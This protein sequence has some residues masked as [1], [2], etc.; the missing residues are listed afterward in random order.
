MLHEAALQGVGVALL[1]MFMCENNLKEG[2]LVAPLPN[3]RPRPGIYYAVV[4]SRRGMRPA[5]RAFLDFLNET[6]R[7]II[8]E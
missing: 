7:Q 3:W 4:L 1:P 2:T 6:Q 8:Q 5:I